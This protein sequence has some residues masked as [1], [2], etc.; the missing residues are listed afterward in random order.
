MRIYINWFRQR[1]ALIN[2]IVRR[3]QKF[4]QLRWKSSQKKKTPATTIEKGADQKGKSDQGPKRRVPGYLSLCTANPDSI[5]VANYK[6]NK[7]LIEEISRYCNKKGVEFLLVSINTKAYQPMVEKRYKDL[8]PSFQATFFEDDL[9][10][11]SES[12]NIEYLGLHRIFNQSYIKDGKSLQWGH[13][14][15]NGHRVVADT[16]VAKLAPLIKEKY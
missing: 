3:Y 7:A 14:N 15:Y 2:L 8:D 16:L 4:R 5:Y 1:S 9:R 10:S 11:F 13:W 6:I 12:R